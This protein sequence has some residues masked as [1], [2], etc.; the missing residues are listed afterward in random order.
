MSWVSQKLP[1]QLTSLP[2]RNTQNPEFRD[3]RREGLSQGRQQQPRI[4]ILNTNPSNTS[5]SPNAKLIRSHA[6]KEGH[7][8]QR[9]RRRGH[10]EVRHYQPTVPSIKYKRHTSEEEHKTQNQIRPQTINNPDPQSF[11]VRYRRDPLQ[12]YARTTS[13]VENELIDHYVRCVVDKGYV[14]CGAR[15]S[16]GEPFMRRVSSCW[17][18]WSLMNDGLLAGLLMTACR[19]V[20]SFQAQNE[21]HATLRLKYKN[22][23][24]RIVRAA[25]SSTKISDQ[26]IALALVLA[27]E[28]FIAGNLTEYRLHGTGIIKTVN[29]RGGI[30]NLGNA[31]L[32]HL[33]S[34]SV[35]NPALKMV[36]GQDPLPLET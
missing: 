17:V 18:P 11:L 16:R 24:I 31:F 8:R 27:A 33:L 4:W 6:A 20:I 3:I 5:K 29:I 10:L 2:R 32:E 12:S 36:Y 19:S 34:K 30:N 21:Y 13:H 7:Y 25:L 15:S 9:E 22:E 28:E 23:S 26:T 14:N 1:N 35:Y